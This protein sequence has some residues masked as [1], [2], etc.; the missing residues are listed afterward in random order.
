MRAA[1]GSAGLGL[2]LKAAGVVKRSDTA[3][4]IPSEQGND[5]H[6]IP[7]VKARN[8][9]FSKNESG[10]DKTGRRLYFIGVS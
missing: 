5:N 4:K 3:Q 2:S 8:P 1:S 6:F 10:S 7:R 9:H